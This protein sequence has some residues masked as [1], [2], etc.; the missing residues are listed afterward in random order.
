[1]DKLGVCHANHTAMCLDPHL[2]NLGEVGAL[3]PV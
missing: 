1:M 3:K 2:N